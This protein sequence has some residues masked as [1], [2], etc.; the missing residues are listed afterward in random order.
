MMK[1]F[2]LGCLLLS[3]TGPALAA[4]KAAPAK[5]AVSSAI[6]ANAPSTPSSVARRGGAV[7]RSEQA[8]ASPR[9]GSKSP[10]GTKPLWREW[11]VFTRSGLPA[12]FYVEEVTRKAGAS[13][14]S[15]TQVIT[16]GGA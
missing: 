14:V 2:L 6:T 10:E 16:E 11:Y 9:R 4:P 5:T 3:S 13:E 8:A 12:G 7:E 15:F 1:F